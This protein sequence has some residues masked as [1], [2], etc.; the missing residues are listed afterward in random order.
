LDCGLYMHIA[1][2]LFLQVAQALVKECK[3]NL[4][5]LESL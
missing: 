1:H 4:V 2:Y 5:T 3:K